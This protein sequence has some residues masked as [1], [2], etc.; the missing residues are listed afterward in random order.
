MKPKS[1]WS[2]KAAL[3]SALVMA[4][5][6]AQ[7][8]GAGKVH[9]NSAPLFSIGS[10]VMNGNLAGLGNEV[11]KVTFTATGTVQAMCQNNGGKQAPGR[12]PIQAVITVTDYF[13]ST[14]NGLAPVEMTAPDP[15]LQDFPSSP[16]PKEAG[17]PNG[18]WKVVDIIQDL[19]YWTGARIL[20]QDIHDT[21]LIDLSYQ[22]TTTYV[23]GVGQVSC[24]EN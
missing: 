12:N 10:L 1:K 2:I 7:A 22:C 6:L 3:L 4:L 17:C 5:L 9:F 19:T 11:A 18:K 14:T 8:A 23:N 20:V 13:T 21:V 24:Q 15:T 16:T